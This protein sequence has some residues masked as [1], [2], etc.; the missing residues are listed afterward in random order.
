L[1]DRFEIACD[2]ARHNK[3]EGILMLIESVLN[4]IPLVRNSNTPVRKL[5][6]NLLVYFPNCPHGFATNVLLLVK[7]RC[8]FAERVLVY[9]MVVAQN[10]R[11]LTNR[12][13]P[14]L[15]LLVEL[16]KQWTDSTLREKFSESLIEFCVE[17]LSQAKFQFDIQHRRLAVLLLRTVLHET[18][19]IKTLSSALYV[20]IVR[21]SIAWMLTDCPKTGEDLTAVSLVLGEVA[22]SHASVWP[23]DSVR[24]LV[25]FA[26]AHFGSNGNKAVKIKNESLKHTLRLLAKA[27]RIAAML[28]RA[29]YTDLL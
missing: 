1:F 6:A 19:E 25:R 23:I 10:L 26:L 22:N 27:P 16:H 18:A 13:A 17:V 11:S 12:E 8:V 4:L 2:E 29:G 20:E 7:G 9:E 21:V 28:V 24:L 3:T 15:L 14:A 5:I